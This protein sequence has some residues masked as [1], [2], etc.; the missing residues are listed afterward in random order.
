MTLHTLPIDY[1]SFKKL[2]NK[3]IRFFICKLDKDYKEGDLIHFYDPLEEIDEGIY[4]DNLFK[5]TYIGMEIDN[6]LNKDYCILSI[7]KIQGV[8][9][10]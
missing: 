9:N 6:V 10:V 7:D 1:L 3:Q 8:E 2:L 5:I 4:K